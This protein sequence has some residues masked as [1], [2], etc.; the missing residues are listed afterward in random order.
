MLWHLDTL[1]VDW[2]V[3]TLIW[4][5][6]MKKKSLLEDKRNNEAQRSHTPQNLKRHISLVSLLLWHKMVAVRCFIWDLGL[7]VVRE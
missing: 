4:F 3:N 5:R 2:K 1:L 6:Y 7:Q